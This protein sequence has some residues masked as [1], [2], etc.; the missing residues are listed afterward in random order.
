MKLLKVIVLLAIIAVAPSFAADKV[1][2]KTQRDSISYTVGSNW[3]E[4]MKADSLYLNIDMLKAGIQDALMGN[5]MALTAEEM[6][7]C[8]KE[9]S[10]QINERKQ[11]VQAQ[12]G[13]EAAEKGKKF[14]DENGKRKGVVTTASG[15]QYEVLTPGDPTKKKPTASS[16]VKVHYEGTLLDGKKFDSSYDRKEPIEFELNRVIP[17]WT[18]GLQLMS[19]GAK[20]KL[21][22][23]GEL[24]YG[25]RG[26]GQD[27]GP[28]ET[29]IFTVELLEVLS[30]PAT[31]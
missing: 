20:Y 22:I 28:N 26:A 9:L 7:T 24:A 15:L 27:I 23:P 31:K 25:S 16:K 18:E 14:L 17:G 30:N 3:G 5:K 29:L 6:A 11:R 10:E 21:F 13:A 1:E 2:F 8:F 19:E 12:K 4:M